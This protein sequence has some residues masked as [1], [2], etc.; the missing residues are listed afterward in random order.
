[1]KFD[2]E[3]AWW[4]QRWPRARLGWLA[5]SLALIALVWSAA[6]AAAQLHGVSYTL[7]PAAEFI[8][9]DDDADMKN[10]ELFGGRF[11]L[12]FGEYVD[13]SAHYLMREDVDTD[14]TH[15]GLTAV[16]H[17]SN[18]N[19]TLRN[20]GG[21]LTLGLTPG[22]V[23]P[24][25]RVGGGVLRFD[26]DVGRFRDQVAMSYGGGVRVG[27][28]HVALEVTVEDFLFR[29][30]RYSLVPEAAGAPLPPDPEEGAAKHNLLI[31]AGLNFTFGGYRGE[32][33][34]PGDE[35]LI[36]RFRYGLAGISIPIEPFAG[37]L[38]FNNSLALKDQRVIGARAGFDLG[39]YLGLRGYYWRGVNHDFSHTE[40]IGSWGGEAN[41]HLSK[42]SWFQPFLV[43]GLGELNFY[44]GFRDVNGAKRPDRTML[45]LGG[46]ADLQVIDHVAIN[47]SARD[48]L[49]GTG[50]LQNVAGTDELHSNWLFTGGLTFTIGRESNEELMARQYRASDY[51]ASEYTY[52]SESWTPEEGY[53]VSNYSYE[54]EAEYYEPQ[55]SG[56]AAPTQSCEATGHTGYISDR[57]RDN[58]R[59]I[60]H[61]E[62]YRLW[63]EDASGWM[64]P[65]AYGEPESYYD[66]NQCQTPGQWQSY[67][68][69]TAPWRSGYYNESQ[70][71]YEWGTYSPEGVP[72]LPHR[73]AR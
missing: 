20:W 16:D 27:W 57:D 69:Y 50:E 45:I 1:M 41:L 22:T 55:Y 26:P 32:G 24:F 17:V 2:V 63:Q 42:E 52:E 10:T 36:D 59:S 37:N 38:E 73:G 68:G 9:W 18:Q 34:G 5:A 60:I 14:N 4:R 28:E 67:Y 43:A 61:E 64:A 3:A 11:T 70:R 58:L 56:S 23:M 62:L 19:V 51:T 54:P 39:Q 13:L 44:K 71:T 49:F 12:N 7:Q 31:G 6:P 48:N 46:G 30:N 65:G 21:E 15:R 66:Y 72:L 40:K 53:G 35:A 25:L 8:K 33:A 47:L 29:F